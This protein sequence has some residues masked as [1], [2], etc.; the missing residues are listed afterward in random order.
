MSDLQP[1]GDQAPRKPPT[2]SG[3]FAPPAPERT[4]FP[5]VA[6]VVAGLV[7]LI[8][9]GV[10]LVAGHRKPPAPGNTL[11]PIAA[12][13]ANLVISQPAMSESTN[14]S[15]GKYTYIDGHIK[16]TGTQTVTGVTVQVVFRNE[17]NLPP[18]IETVP[19]ALIR[20]H[21]PYI[22]TVPVSAAPLK[23]GDERE[24]RLTFETIPVNWNYQMPE[25]RITGVTTK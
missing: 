17:V 22:D 6:W 3:L 24:F 2:D 15:G 11:Q 7:V 18:Q 16:N 12:Y 9:L 10:L 8:V 4:G 5:T 13:A 23:P 20:T 14:L 21:E 19:L 25:I 1:A